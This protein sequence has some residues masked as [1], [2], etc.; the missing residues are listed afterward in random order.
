MNAEPG[1]MQYF[2]DVEIGTG[3]ETASRTLSKDEII[4]FAREF[5]PQPF[6]LDEAAAKQSLYGG[7]IASGWHTASVMMRLL[8]DTFVGRTASIGSPGFD[9]L[10][11]LKPVR[12]G[13]TIRARSVCIEKTPSKSRPD[14][15]SVKFHT[16]VFNQRDEVVMSLTSIG[17]Y[18]KRPAQ[19]N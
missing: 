4:E 5:D 6:H 8:V 2:E 13:D 19:H 1:R 10:R 12:P 15:G 3:R 7:L 11:W 16:E 14:L 18:L 9:N 17:L